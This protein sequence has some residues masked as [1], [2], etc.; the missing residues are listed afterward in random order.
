MASST[1][2]ANLIN[3]EVENSDA[4]SLGCDITIEEMDVVVEE[5]KLNDIAIAG[6]VKTDGI[7]VDIDHDKNNV[8]DLDVNVVIDGLNSSIVESQVVPYERV[9]EI[10]DLSPESSYE[11]GFAAS[12]KSVK[13]VKDSVDSL[14]N[15]VKS[16]T[17]NIS[18]V[19]TDI[20]SLTRRVDRLSM[21]EGGEDLGGIWYIDELTGNLVTDKQVEIRS[22]IIAT[23]EVSAGGAGSEGGSTGGG[24]LD[25][26]QLQDYLDEHEYVTKAGLEDY[27]TKQDVVN[28]INPIIQTNT[29]QDEDIQNIITRLEEAEKITQKFGIDEN[30][31]YV[32]ENFRSSKEISAGGAGTEEE[33]PSAGLDEE[34]LKEYLDEHKYVTEDRLGELLPDDYYTTQEIDDKFNNVAAALIV[35]NAKDTEQDT[36]I[37]NLRTNDTKQDTEIQSIIERLEKAETITNKF[38][39][40]E[41]G[42]HTDENIITT[43]EVSAG[44]AGAESNPE[45]GQTSGEYK[46]YTHA[47]ESAAKVWTI[48]HG[49]GKYPNVKVVDSTHEL[50]YGDV[51]Y[52]N[53]DTV[54]IEFGAPFGGMAYLD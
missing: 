48:V 13:K 47:Q 2:V 36:A 31:I 19:V 7:S 44:G 41:D 3:R 38:T 11:K 37:S 24:G 1:V 25:E 20:E 49:L 42:I 30:G 6:V 51:K 21:S 33:N 52:P 17:S 28:S 32:D 34:Q 23:G 18:K 46:M 5:I 16:N 53:I 12:A 27:A 9:I 22:N 10:N 15:N 14:D 8:M 45:G 4:W 43:K 29:K 54:T 50:C 39:V 40:D 26:D 35:I